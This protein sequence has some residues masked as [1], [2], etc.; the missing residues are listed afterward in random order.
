[1]EDDTG[2]TISTID[3]ESVADITTSNVSTALT[4]VTEPGSYPEG[5]TSFTPDLVTPRHEVSR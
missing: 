5:H 4:G 3:V 1:M 2:S